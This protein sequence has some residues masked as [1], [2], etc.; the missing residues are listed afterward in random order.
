M[1]NLLDPKLDYVFKH[2]FGQ[3]ERKSLLISFLNSLLKNKPHIKELTLENTET[4]KTLAEDKASRL[5]VKATSDDGTKLDIE[6]QCR[7]TGEIPER[8]FAYMSEA[9][10]RITK[11]GESYKKVKIISIWILRD[12]VTNRNGAISEAVMTF[13]PTENDTSEVLTDKGRIFFIELK[14]FNPQKADAHD[15][16]TAWLSFL[17]N[18]VLMNTSF[19]EEEEVSKA[20][21]TL[22]YMSADEKIRAAA[23][24][25]QRT[26]NDYNSEITVA[27]ERGELKK[28]REMALGLLQADV[29]VDIIAQTSGLS[30]DEIK[31]LKHK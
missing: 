8:A 6:I 27:E 11:V 2:I 1:I 12:N 10:P 31:S 17:K 24:L 19:L 3:E 15:L 28:A 16:L 18:P 14:K 23:D 30:V 4:D 21:D 9:I 22:K 7:N 25:R 20:M 5:D 13:L 29:A 26:L